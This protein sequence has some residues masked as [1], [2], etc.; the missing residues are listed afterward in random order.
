MITRAGRAAQ[1][2]PA[3]Q[4]GSRS[5]SPPPPGWTKTTVV[6]ET[7]TVKPGVDG[8]PRLPKG[9]NGSFE[10]LDVATTEVE[11][12]TATPGAEQGEEFMWPDDVF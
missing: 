9:A 7:V 5:G 11:I 4:G 12:L 10:S 3:R 2:H 8:V 1:E 6:E